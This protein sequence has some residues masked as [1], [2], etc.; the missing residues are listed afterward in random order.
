[1]SS[2]GLRVSSFF[3]QGLT[4]CEVLFVVLLVIST[5]I[6]ALRLYVRKR[7]TERKWCLDDYFVVLAWVPLF[8]ADAN[9]SFACLQ[10]RPGISGWFNFRLTT[11]GPRPLMRSLK[12]ERLFSE[13]C[14]YD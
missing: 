2:V 14:A 8:Q 11:L 5:I 1:M 3:L 12:Y 13:D 4:F 6:T 10:R 7:V 9:L